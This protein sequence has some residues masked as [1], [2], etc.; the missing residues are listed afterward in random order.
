[1]GVAGRVGLVRLALHPTRPVSAIVVSFFRW[2]VL[3]LAACPA[4]A[5]TCRSCLPAARRNLFIGVANP[6]SW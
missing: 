3:P 1:V 5:P 4:V 6:L 2:W